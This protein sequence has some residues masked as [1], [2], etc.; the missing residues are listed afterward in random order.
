[1]KQSEAVSTVDGDMILDL[2]SSVE[3]VDWMSSRRKKK[4]DKKTDTR[5]TYREA[6]PR[7]SLTP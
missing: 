7:D 6:M 5:R 3:N 1:M 2:A 4:K